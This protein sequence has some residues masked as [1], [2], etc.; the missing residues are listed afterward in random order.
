MMKRSWTIVPLIVLFTLL[1]DGCKKAVVP[2]YLVIPEWHFE[3]DPGQGTSSQKITELWV[4]QDEQLLG[5]YNTP[6][7][8]PITKLG[9]SKILIMAGIKNNGISDTRIR[10]PFIEPL[11]STIDFQSEQEVTW[12]PTFHYN[13]NVDVEELGFESGNFL[14]QL[15]GNNGSFTAI[16]NSDLVFEGNRSGK[17]IIDA[18]GSRLFYKDDINRYLTAGNYYFLEMNYSANNRFSVGLLVTEATGETKE[19]VLA[20]NPTQETDG[21]PVWNKIYVDFGAIPLKHP[22]ALFYEFYIEA[23]PSPIGKPV[24]VYLDNLKWVKWQ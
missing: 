12:S 8:I 22:N 4:Y 10:Y 11:D 9:S 17:G 7:K 2:A 19:F 1:F 23:V 15:P 24:E 21:V 5:I 14:V 13:A 20:I 16:S 3:S 18:T 6:A